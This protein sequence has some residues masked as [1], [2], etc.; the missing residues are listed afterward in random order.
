MRNAIDSIPVS[1]YR[2]CY[3]ETEYFLLVIPRIRGRNENSDVAS[4]DQRQDQQESLLK[5]VRNLS[6]LEMELLGIIAVSLCIPVV[7]GFGLIALW[8]ARS[9]RS[10]HG[11]TDTIFFLSARNSQGT[12]R[13]AW[14]F[15]ASSIGA[16]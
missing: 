10:E 4:S 3:V 12:A 2:V 14:S 1:T 7:L 8:I 13:V 15:Y 6:F 9:Y 16:G 5:V 11:E